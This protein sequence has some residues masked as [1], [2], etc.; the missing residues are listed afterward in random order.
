MVAYR[1]TSNTTGSATAA[2]R[3][4]SDF[5][6]ASRPDCHRLQL[7]IETWNADSARL[8]EAC[9]YEREG[10]LRKAGYSNAADPPDV[11]VYARVRG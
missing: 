6:L 5:F 3:T 10:I 11:F 9:G 8:A 4:F 2:L 7:I 1:S